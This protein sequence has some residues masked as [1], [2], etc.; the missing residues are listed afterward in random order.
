MCDVCSIKEIDWKFKHGENKARL[1]K[2]FLYRFIAGFM[3]ELELCSLCDRELFYNGEIKFLS[4]YEELE[5]KINKNK[6][7]YLKPKIQAR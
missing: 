6:K 5:G 3:V 7:K 2:A 4:D 1:K